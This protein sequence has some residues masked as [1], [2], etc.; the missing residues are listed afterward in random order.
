MFADL[1]LA[2]ERGPGSA[3]VKPAIAPDVQR[4]RDDRPGDHRD[5]AVPA[6]L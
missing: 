2:R 3:L 5:Q 1:C 4:R 6:G